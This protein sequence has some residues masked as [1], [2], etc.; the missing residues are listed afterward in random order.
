[1]ITFTDMLAT[2]TWATLGTLAA[3]L[4]AVLLIHVVDTFND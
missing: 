3:G 4:L 1:M 2:F